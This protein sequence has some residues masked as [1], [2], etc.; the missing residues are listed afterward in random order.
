MPKLTI[1]AILYRGMVGQTLIIKSFAFEEKFYSV[2]LLQSG[3]VNF[4]RLSEMY[5]L[6]T[7][8]IIL[9][10]LNSFLNKKMYF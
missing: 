10:R 8:Q 9:K 4:I 6:N 2:N 5:S 1:R 3:Q 7:Y